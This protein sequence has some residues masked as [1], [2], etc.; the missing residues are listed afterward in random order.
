MDN[1]SLNNNEY[2]EDIVTLTSPDGEKIDFIEIAGI[3][4]KDGFYLILQPVELLEGMTEDE[5]LVF[6]V[7]QT[8]DGEEKFE[9]ELDEEIIEAVFAEYDRLCDEAQKNAE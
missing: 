6:K 4:H 9:I 3:A 1:E 5:A 8:E 7:S 2:E